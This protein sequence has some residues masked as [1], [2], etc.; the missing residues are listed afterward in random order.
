MDLIYIGIG[1]AFF[2]AS[3]WLALLCERLS[4]QRRG[5]GA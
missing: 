2:A 5:G 3:W 4:D 1:V